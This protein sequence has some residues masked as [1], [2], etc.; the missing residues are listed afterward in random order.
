MNSTQLILHL[1]WRKLFAPDQKENSKATK[2][3]CLHTNSILKLMDK[4]GVV[5]CTKDYCINKADCPEIQLEMTAVH[6][7]N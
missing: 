3:L 1:L 5:N 4:N 6:Q 2:R 7:Q